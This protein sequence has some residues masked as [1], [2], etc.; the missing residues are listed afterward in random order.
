MVRETPNSVGNF[1]IPSTLLGLRDGFAQLN[2]WLAG[3]NLKQS[4]RDRA[5]LIYEEIA[6]NI[7]RYAFDDREAHSIEI[8]M[9]SDSETLTFDFFDDG[10]PFDPRTVDPRREPETL[11]TAKIGG[12]G[13]LLVNSAA[14]NVDYERTAEGRNH[15]V[16]VFSRAE[17]IG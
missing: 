10:R 7:M 6:T 3:M 17:R 12:R 14:K 1:V 16:V 2:E 13:L 8:K 4:A 15:L 5:N 11:E 9:R